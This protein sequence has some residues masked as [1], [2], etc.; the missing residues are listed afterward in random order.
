[1]KKALIVLVTVMMTVTLF[2]SCGND[3]FFHYVEFDSNGGTEVERQI[4]RNGEKAT[5]PKDPTKDGTEFVA[6]YDGENVFDFNTEITKDYKLTAKWADDSGSNPGESTSSS[7]TVTFVLNGGT[8]SGCE[9]QTIEAG[10]KAKKPAADPKLTNAV[11]KFWSA[12]GGKTE[13]NF[14]TVITKNTTL[15]AVWQTTF[16]VGDT[17]PA[18]GIIFYVAD[19]EQTSTYGTETFKWKYLEATPSDATYYNASTFSWGDNGSFGTGTAIGDGWVNA[20]KFA[21]DTTESA[22]LAAQVCFA[23]GN[24]TDYDDWFLPSKYELKTMYDNIGSKGTWSFQY[25]SSSES[26]SNAAFAKYFSTDPDFGDSEG[27]DNSARNRELAVRPARAFAEV[28]TPSSSGSSSSGSGSSSASMGSYSIGSTGPAGGYIFYDCD[29]DND[30]TSD[31]AGPDGL[32]SSV[33]GWRY[34]E[35][36]SADAVGDASNNGYFAWG[37]DGTACGTE[38]GIGK[39]K[40]NTESIL[41]KIGDFK[42]AQACAD[43]GNNTNYDDWFLPSIEELKLMYTN[44]KAQGK[45]GT[46]DTTEYYWSSSETDDE[47][48]IALDFSDGTEGGDC[49]GQSNF[50]RVRPIRSFLN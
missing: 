30:S 14:D 31:G 25:W 29:A 34:L 10:G 7:H 11:F 15:T 12:D 48:R 1:M 33:C 4:V 44:L 28:T 43:Y 35:A 41:D 19:T 42:A 47:D 49:G 23:Y 24:D 20:K 5:K 16:K 21:A 8:G 32:K 2:I 18:G 17:G 36:A 45:G 22:L 38:K 26:G 6:W 9:T 13:F 40:N 3:P 37:P 39:G 50:F 27:F 46:W